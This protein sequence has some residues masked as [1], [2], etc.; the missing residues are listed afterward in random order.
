MSVCVDLSLALAFSAALASSAAVARVTSAS[1]FFRSSS[2]TRAKLDEHR[3]DRLGVGPQ[4]AEQHAHVA[5]LGHVADGQVGLQGGA[6][7][8]HR[9]LVEGLRLGRLDLIDQRLEQLG[10]LLGLL[11]FQVHRGHEELA[12]D[13]LRRERL[14]GLGRLAEAGQAVGDP[15]DGL[16]PIGRDLLLFAGSPPALP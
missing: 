15:L 7:D 16:G 14:V 10:R 2:S 13:V 9:G 6:E 11:A 3:V 12:F 1:A 5:R 4:V 8:P